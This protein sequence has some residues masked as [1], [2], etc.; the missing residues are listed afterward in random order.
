MILKGK[1]HNIYC[2]KRNIGKSTSVGAYVEIQ[3]G[4]N[5]GDFCVIQ[6]H[7]FICD[8]VIIGDS[9]FIGHGVMF[10]NDL[11]PKPY[12]ND[13]DLKQTIIEDDVSIG[14]NATILPVRIG[15][16]ALIGAGAVVTK[17]VPEFAVVVG[18]PAKILKYKEEAWEK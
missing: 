13:F 2:D 6:S 14:S 16:G 5:I 12:N 8:G 9:C 18:N 15:K 3:A 10:S 11:N 1:F 4:A 7:T 17:D